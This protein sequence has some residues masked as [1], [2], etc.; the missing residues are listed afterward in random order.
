M[1]WARHCPQNLSGSVASAHYLLRRC[2]YSRYKGRFQV[3]SLAHTAQLGISSSASYPQQHPQ[4]H[5]VQVVTLTASWMAKLSATLS[6]R[7]VVGF[8]LHSSTSSR[9]KS[10]LSSRPFATRPTRI[11]PRRVLVMC[12]V[13]CSLKDKSINAVWGIQSNQNSERLAFL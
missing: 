13:F 7:A 12:S 6:K 9:S 3:A 1:P 10:P 5:P 4:S 11:T 8:S 2:E